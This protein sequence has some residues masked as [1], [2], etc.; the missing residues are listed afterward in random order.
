[1]TLTKDQIDEIVKDTD[2]G[3]EILRQYMEQ[4]DIIPVD[5]LVGIKDKL[6]E[7]QEDETPYLA[8]ND[9]KMYVIGDPNK[10]EHKAFDY[11]LKFRF[12]KDIESDGEIVG[13][14]KI[15]TRH[16]KNVTIKPKND[17]KIVDAIMSI[18]PFFRKI[19][20]DGVGEYTEE[21]MRSVLSSMSDDVISGMY[22]VVAAVLDLNP[23]IAEY[24]MP[25]SML[26][27]LGQMINDFPEVFNESDAF[28]GWSSARKNPN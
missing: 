13:N 24:M 4:N 26:D 27:A 28:F 12:P 15:V 16:Y 5:D 7:A 23:S 6:D 3:K 10:T 14:Y 19:T 20:E 2:E 25:Y 9:D 22:N 18:E 17:L 8:I 1:M 11:T 21:E